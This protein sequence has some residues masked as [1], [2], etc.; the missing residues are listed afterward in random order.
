[1][2]PEGGVYGIHQRKERIVGSQ[3]LAESLFDTLSESINLWY[4]NG[5]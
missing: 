1:M 2:F 4:V 5:N 3:G